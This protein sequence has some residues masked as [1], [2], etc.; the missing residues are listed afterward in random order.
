[1]K[2]TIKLIG[3]I[4]FIAVIGFS[5]IACD[6][7]SGSSG[8]IVPSELRG[9]WV[10]YYGTVTINS[11]S[12]TIHETGYS[13][14][15]VPIKSVQKGSTVQAQDGEYY[16]VYTIIVNQGNNAIIGLSQDK[17]TIVDDDGYYFYKQ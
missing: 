6:D 5:M 7:G 1:M 12:M 2:N 9:T 3:I 13:P 16:T 14:R 11:S 8:D 4:A 15:N 10:G 17:K